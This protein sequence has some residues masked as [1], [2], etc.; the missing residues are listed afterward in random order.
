MATTAKLLICAAMC[1]SLF[2]AP[3][4]L[5][6]TE[7]VSRKRIPPNPEDVALHQKLVDAQDAVGRKDYKAA[8]Q[9][10]EDYLAKKPADAN[11]HF[12]L[13]YVYSALGRAA[14]ATSEYEH[15]IALDP[16]ML[17]AYQNLGLTLL[18]TDPAAAV[19]PLQE[20]VELAPGQPQP[21][22]LLG[23]ALERTG[24]LPESIEQYRAAEKLDAT[25]FDVHFALGRALL[26]TGHAAD[27]EPEFRA[28]IAERPAA[29]EPR[30]GLAESLMQEK[31]TPAA[32]AEF[33]A[34]L[35]AQPGDN[36]ARLEYATLLDRT[37]HYDD[38]LTQLNEAT[39]AQPEDLG[40]LKL[41]A[42]I[43]FD[44]KQYAAA[45]PVLEKAA[46]LAPGDADVLAELG[47][48]YVEQKD[49]PNAVRALGTALKIQPNANDILGEL[50]TAQY[51]GKNYAAA[52]E[53]L[54]LLAKRGTLSPGTWF[55]RADCYDKM[56]EAAQALEAYQRFLQLNAN[57]NSDFYFEASARVRALK[58]ELEKK[59]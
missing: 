35:Q 58:R 49:Y 13:G 15:A 7:S 59:R 28:A 44:Q 16:K 32:M 10:Y 33:A 9:D 56:G 1:G 21:K 38:A 43:Y 23:D 45:I 42:Q 39:K 51:L 57:R 20:A 14:D 50:V 22:F 18:K 52:L 29:A 30:M 19:A 5:G 41:R 40:S 25:N 53:G 54:D 47:H 34:Y 27:A 12:N 11:V 17:S 6:Q 37:G 3:G 26:Q 24:K 4:A 48:L 2:A 8:A 31:K 46:A 36:K 55:V